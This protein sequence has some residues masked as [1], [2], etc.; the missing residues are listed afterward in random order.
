MRGREI[1]EE[2]EING[3]KEEDEGEK[4]LLMYNSCIFLQKPLRMQKY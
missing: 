2:N 1:G 3:G 4:K